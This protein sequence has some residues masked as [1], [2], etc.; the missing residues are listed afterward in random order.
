LSRNSLAAVSC[1]IIWDFS[2]ARRKARS[3]MQSITSSIG[4]GVCFKTAD[5]LLIF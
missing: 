4:K 1:S 3:Y 5:L 2:V